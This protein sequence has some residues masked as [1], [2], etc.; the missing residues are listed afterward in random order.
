MADRNLKEHLADYYGGQSLPEPVAS[1][2][3]HAA[4][5]TELRG[6]DER[7]GT[8][9]VRSDRPIAPIE[10]NDKIPISL[11]NLVM[12]CCRPNA[13]ERPTDMKQLDARLAT[14][15]KLW[16]TYRQSLRAQRGRRKSES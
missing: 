1:Q 8:N 16:R 13:A 9:L 5:P 11:S 4:N 15:Q 2:L 3:E 12:E 14:V 7:S 6:Q 10:L